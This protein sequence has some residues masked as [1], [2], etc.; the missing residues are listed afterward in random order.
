MTSVTDMRN[1]QP[2][3]TE[4]DLGVA[5]DGECSRE[6]LRRELAAARRRV[7]ELERELGERRIPAYAAPLLN[8]I[9]EMPVVIF[10]IDEAGVVRDALGGGF[11]S[12]PGPVGASV[13]ANVREAM[14]Q[15]AETLDR[16]LAGEHVFAPSS[17]T[18]QGFE[19]HALTWMAPYVDSAGQRFAVGA[20]LDIG[21]LRHAQSE[22]EQSERRYRSMAS[23]VPVGIVQT[24]A[25]GRCLY[26][27]EA[28][29]ELLG[30]PAARLRDRHWLD[31]VHPDDRAE[32]AARWRDARPSPQPV[33][34]SYRVIR[35]DGSSRWVLGQGFA[36]RDADGR[37]LGFTGSI[38]DI[39]DHKRVEEEI[40]SANEG[41][42]RRIE[43]RTRRLDAAN[44]E[45]EALCYSVSHDLRTPLRSID[46]FCHAL[47]EEFAD[48]LGDT[49][50]DYLAR[51]RAASQRM[52][53]LIDDLLM[54][55]RVTRGQLQWQHIDLSAL[56]RDVQA[57][58][59]DTDPSRVVEWT[60]ADGLGCDGDM[61]MMRNVLANLLGNSWKFTSNTDAARIGLDASVDDEGRTVFRVQDNGA[62]FP[63][64]FGHKL[65]K[66]FERLHDAREFPGTGIG[67]A[68][69]ERIVARHGGSV[70]A[71]GRPGEGATFYFT[72]AE[73]GT[74][75]IRE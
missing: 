9:F 69:V 2:D 13:G 47:M 45:L 29:A 64:D 17:G 15:V 6:A 53:E 71:E 4:R 3:P 36:E 68:V 22:L 46:G 55:S 11:R 23:S 30:A 37:L 33:Q 59:C 50:L 35:D 63:S 72:L 31:L 57:E 60:I 42:A 67:L 74:S 43:E 1:P 24:D 12:A 51:A 7:R 40:R 52:G 5:A 16:V 58:L 38:T 56:A 48:R 49:G 25:E 66:P 26:A 41:L 20:A 62:G 14:P 61:A 10:R 32:F 28:A 34:H 75:P 8:G 27:N 19:W 70:W 21:D 44:R 54:M 18:F 73:S 65:F 39:A